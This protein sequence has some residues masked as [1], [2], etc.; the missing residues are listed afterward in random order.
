M[1]T[2][3]YREFVLEQLGRVRP[4]AARKMF[5]AVGIYADG[6]FF[7]L[8]DDDTLYFKVDDLTR[9][10]Y[11]AEGMG[12]FMPGGDPKQ[13]MQYYQV[14]PEALE[15]PDVLRPWMETAIEVALRARRRRRKG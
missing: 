3:A 7:A 5:G 11:E 10:S 9:P 2:D 4:V 13:V 8:I 15:E 14:P 12:P 6:L 1:V